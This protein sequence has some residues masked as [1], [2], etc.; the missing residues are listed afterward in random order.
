MG[1]E[2]KIELWFINN[3]PKNVLSYSFLKIELVDLVRE[4]SETMKIKFR[5]S[6]FLKIKPNEIMPEVSESMKQKFNQDLIDLIHKT[7]SVQIK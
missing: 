7:D 2:Y 3:L 6:P 4:A 5:H 1:N